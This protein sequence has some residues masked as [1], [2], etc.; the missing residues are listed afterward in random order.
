MSKT[1]PRTDQTGFR[2]IVKNCGF[3]AIWIYRKNAKNRKC[4]QKKVDKMKEFRQSIVVLYLKAVKAEMTEMVQAYKNVI[5][6]TYENCENAENK[7]TKFI[8]KTEADFERFAKLQ[9]QI[10]A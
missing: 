4:S 7:A 2:Y 8:A 1:G 5:L 6:L 10:N 3:E 9:A